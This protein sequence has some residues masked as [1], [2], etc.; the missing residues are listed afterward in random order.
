MK[1]LR[2]SAANQDCTMRSPICNHN[3]ETTVLAHLNK[4][5]FGKGKGLK[6]NDMA[7]LYCCSACHDL[8]DGRIPSYGVDPNLTSDDVYRMA[9]E[10]VVETHIVMIKNGIIG[11]V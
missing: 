9:L 7:A 1:N 3:N 5:R 4:L 6:A 10:G 11:C 8:L 2:Q